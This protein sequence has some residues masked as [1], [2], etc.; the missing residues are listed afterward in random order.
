MKKEIKVKYS[1]KDLKD[2]IVD[3]IGNIQKIIIEQENGDKHI[4]EIE[5]VESIT[6]SEVY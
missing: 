2:F 6:L 1:I 3:E 5:R 4:Y